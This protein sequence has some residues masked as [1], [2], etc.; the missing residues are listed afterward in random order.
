MN[1]TAKSESGNALRNVVAG[2]IVAAALAAGS[3]WWLNRG[4][5]G[6]PS[7]PPEAITLANSMA[8][9]GSS[10]IALAQAKGYFE[11]AGLQVA[12]QPFA[13]GKACLDAMI[14]G[15]ADFAT[16]ADIPF[17]FATLRAAPVKAIATMS[18]SGG[19]YG[20][21]ARS[22]RGI[23]SPANLVGK[24][25]GATQ[26][27]SGHFW[28]D[29]YL[30]RQHVDSS[31]IKL[32]NLAPDK[33]AAALSA[34]EV[35]AVVTW[36]PYFGAVKDALASNARVFTATGIYD[37]PWILATTRDVAGKRPEAIRRL[38]HALERA[39][40]YYASEPAAARALLAELR[41]EDPARLNAVLDFFRFDLRLGQSLL[42]T[43]E[44]ESRWAMRN[45][46]T[47]AE[48]VPNFLD[49]VYTEGLQSVNPNAVT[50]IR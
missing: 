10:L 17:M 24:R 22:D 19:E 18:T 2:V 26:G 6:R 13:T 29:A 40:R 47:S 48:K 14:E 15:K 12:I 49:H 32:V 7:G 9:P 39:N 42:G 11:A 46:L 45:K 35:D 34:G 16:G 5:D 27:T 8:Y 21:V 4:T 38:L 33:M 20:I 31:R 30:V 1:A 23:S 43:L 37:S 3:Y 28:L 36:E 44:D 41:K 25:M 50:I